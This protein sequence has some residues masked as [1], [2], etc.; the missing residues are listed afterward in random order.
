M[1]KFESSQSQEKRSS[2]RLQFSRSAKVYSPLTRRYYAARTID[3]SRGGAM[4]SVSSPRT[5]LPGDA[6]E[7]AIAWDDRTLI[8]QT[9]MMRAQVTRVVGR[10]GEHQAVGV[11][12]T[13]ELAMA[14]AA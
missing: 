14:A 13:D 10:M 7:I 11:R 6:I 9:S 1:L 12:F 8:P 3:M 4:I 2:P 5:L